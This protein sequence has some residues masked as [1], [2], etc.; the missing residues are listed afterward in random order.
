MPIVWTRI[1]AIEP[2]PGCVGTG[3]FS[4][5]ISGID[6]VAGHRQLPAVAN[7]SFAGDR[8]A[9]VDQAVAGLA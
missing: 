3:S 5:I 4:Q 2:F 1:F 8:S 7:M 6:W 9:A